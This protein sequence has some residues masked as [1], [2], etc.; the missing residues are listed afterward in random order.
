MG[1]LRVLARV[2]GERDRLGRGG[3]GPDPVARSTRRRPPASVER[4]VHAHPWGEALS[5]VSKRAFEPEV[6]PL[7][8]ARFRRTMTASLAAVRKH[9]AASGS[10]HAS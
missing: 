4:D 3:V 2:L 1:H 6:V 7:L 8:R 5:E 9:V 10:A